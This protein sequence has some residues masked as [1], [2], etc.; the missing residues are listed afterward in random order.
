MAA[1]RARPLPETQGGVST[2]PTS[3]LRT[4]LDSRRA[5]RRTLSLDE[6]IATIVPLT[7]DLQER[8]A[9][10]EKLWVHPSCVAPGADGLARI[11]PDR[12]K[13]PTDSRDRVCMAPEL[14]QTLEPGNARASVFAL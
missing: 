12:C 10:G 2:Q 5:E 9:R 7:M 4:L 6:A 1:S 11:V 14:M 13:M 8:H 3:T